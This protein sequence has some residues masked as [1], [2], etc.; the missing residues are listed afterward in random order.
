MAATIAGFNCPRFWD[1]SMLPGVRKT[2]CFYISKPLQI[3]ANSLPLNLVFW[4]L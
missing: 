2:V 4:T 3:V 1:S